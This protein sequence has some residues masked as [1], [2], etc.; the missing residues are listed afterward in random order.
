MWNLKNIF[1]KTTPSG[2]VSIVSALEHWHD[3][4]TRCRHMLITSTVYDWKTILTFRNSCPWCWS[5]LSVPFNWTLWSWCVRPDAFCMF[6]TNSFPV[7][8]LTVHHIYVFKSKAIIFTIQ[9]PQKVLIEFYPRT[10]LS[11]RSCVE[12]QGLLRSKRTVL[13]DPNHISFPVKYGQ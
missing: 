6:L 10:P 13:N 3:Y 12:L 2:G 5:G 11:P 9:S 1:L 4:I 8:A 7:W